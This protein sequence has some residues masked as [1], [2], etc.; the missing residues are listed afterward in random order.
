[1]QKGLSRSLM[2]QDSPSTIP[3][4]LRGS[5]PQRSNGIPSVTRTSAHESPKSSQTK[6]NQETKSSLPVRISAQKNVFIR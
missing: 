5:M 1:M 4:R 6:P 2:A 3:S